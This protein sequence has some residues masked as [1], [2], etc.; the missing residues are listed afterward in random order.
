MGPLVSLSLDAIDLRD[1]QRDFGITKDAI[2]PTLT[3]RPMRQLTAQLGLS[4]E[5]NEVI[6]RVGLL[7]KV[8]TQFIPPLFLEPIRPT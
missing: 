4:T 7:Q 8:V 2:V 5:I 3:Y 1:N 6:R